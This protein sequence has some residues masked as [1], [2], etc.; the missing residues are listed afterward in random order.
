M[1]RKW[2]YVIIAGLVIAC[3]L[4]VGYVVGQ[5][6]GRGSPFSDRSM[7]FVF[8]RMVEPLPEARRKAI[9][10]SVEQDQ[11]R[12]RMALRTLNRTRKQVHEQTLAPEFD[13]DAVAKTLAEMR[14]QL[15]TVKA[16]QDELWLP[17]MQQLTM[18]ERQLLLRH[19]G[20]RHEG[21]NGSATI[22]KTSEK[23]RDRGD[24]STSRA[25]PDIG[26]TED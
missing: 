11:K 18:E 4:L 19:R 8:E 22:W 3:L 15:Q 16:I 25:I 7:F 10:E 12:L 20:G 1:N 14:T 13:A 6:L 24:R 17:I 23:P 2:L 21:R 5:K 9:V 26:E